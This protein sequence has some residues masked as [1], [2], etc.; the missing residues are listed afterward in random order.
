MSRRDIEFLQNV[1]IVSTLTDDELEVFRGFLDERRLGSGEPVF[2]EGDQESDLYIVR[3]GAVRVLVNAADGAAVEVACLGPGD[4]FGEMALFEDAPRSATCVMDEDGVLLY[5]SRDEMFSLID[6]HPEAAIKVMYRMANITAGRL[7]NTSSFLSD[8]V[9]WGEGARKRAITDDLTGLFNRRY[10]D[11]ALTEQFANARASHTTLA[12]IMMDLDHFHGIN[13]RWGQQ[14]GDMVIAAVAPAV[15]ENLR[16][17]DIAA[18]YGGDEFTLILPNTAAQDALKVA[19]GIRSSVQ[20]LRINLPGVDE[21]ITVT[22]SQ[23]IAEFPRHGTDIDGLREQAD[24]ALYQAKEA[25][26]N[27]AAIA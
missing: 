17:G 9:R 8:M 10:L 21:I 19:E 3:D 6:N 20:Q 24:Q 5:L 16:D 27:R 15:K 1:D 25:G 14:I 11:D 12:L 26:R 4:F 23:G 22:T 7:K 18:R 13:D 2:R